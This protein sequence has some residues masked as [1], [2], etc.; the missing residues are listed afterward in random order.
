MKKRLLLVLAL[1]AALSLV[2]AAPVSADGEKPINGKI[3]LTFVGGSCADPVGP[4]LDLTF[5]SW[6]GTVV[7][8]GTTYGWA[9]FPLTGNAPPAP[10]GNLVYVEEYWTIFTVEDDEIPNVDLACNADLVVLDG[11][12]EA[13]ATRGG[14]ARADGTVFSAADPGDFADVAEGSRMIWR[15]KI[16]DF[17]FKATFH[18]FPLK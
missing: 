5:V 16:T 10:V 9:D 8:D 4:D 14:A 3:D 15:G 7:I 11:F 6:I 1:V 2:A 12:N 13:W 18:I 17:T